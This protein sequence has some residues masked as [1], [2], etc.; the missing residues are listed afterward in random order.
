LSIKVNLA[1]AETGALRVGLAPVHETLLSLHCLLHPWF[2]PLQ[3]PWVREMR[4]LS[5][6][7]KRDVRT[8][9]F[10]YDDATPDCF[11]PHG[12][13]DGATFDAGLAEAAALGDDDLRLA[14]ARPLW[15]YYAPHADAL[16]DAYD[17]VRA[18]A[19]RFGSDTRAVVE[20]LL[21][22]PRAFLARLAEF[23]IAYWDETF[24]ATWNELE[25]LLR[26][27]AARARA[28]IESGDPLALVEPFPAQV[29]VHRDRGMIERMSPHEHTVTPTPDQP[30]TF[31]PSA[32]VWPH[33]RI[34]CDAP[35]PL[36]VAYPAAFVAREAERAPAPSEL[37][38]ALRAAGDPTRLEILRLVSRQSRT[39]EELAAL[40]GLSSSGLSKHLRALTD[41]GLVSSRRDGWY[42]LYSVERERLAALSGDLLGFVDGA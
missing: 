32:Y 36:A 40:V 31:F 30:L 16:D 10:L 8:F 13:D 25:P 15:F 12:A 19:A 21:A 42:V 18:N 7:L 38:R 27:E 26:A 4:S 33:V 39:T 9:A 20:L 3:H 5:A 24:K 23:L 37:A 11:M 34:N 35:W 14:L 17:S 1:A 22:D 2:H 6:E 29:R 28:A 41:A